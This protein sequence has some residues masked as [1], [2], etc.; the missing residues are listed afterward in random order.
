MSTPTRAALLGPLALASALG[1]ARPVAA[2][3]PA[4]APAGAADPVE[5][6][7]AEFRRDLRQLELRR[8]RRLEELAASQPP[9]RAVATYEALFQAALL[10]GLYREVEPTAERLLS[11][12]GAPPALRYQ[13]NL[14]NIL[15]E[16]DRGAFDDS[17]ASIQA[18]ILERR[19]AEADGQPLGA[20]VPEAVRFGLVET[21]YQ[22]LVQASQFEVARRAFTLIR[23]NAADPA[24]R[25]YAEGRLARL[26]MIGQPAPP[27]AGTDVDGRPF[28]LAALKG[29]AVIVHFWATWCLPCGPEALNLGSL[30]DAYHDRG[31]RLVG[32]DLDALQEGGPADAAAYLPTVR[33]FLV[34]HNVRWPVLLDTPGDSGIARAYGVREVP[35]NFLIGPDGTV[36]AVDLAGSGLDAAVRKAL[37]R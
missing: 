3:E 19:K 14:V 15:A 24:M 29:R 11:A 36:L 12:G 16:V 35:A 4:Q 28:D 8:V 37:P 5:A 18:A 31:L 10:G 6:I 34:E 9:E 26:A 20:V 33:R 27:I 21:Y 7:D 2:Q 1:L 22:R 25:E 23:D 32:V 13:A 30:R 17:L